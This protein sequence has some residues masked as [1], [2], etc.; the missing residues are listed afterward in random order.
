MK[1]SAAEEFAVDFFRVPHPRFV[2]VGLGFSCK[3]QLREPT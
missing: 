2:R 3:K 1:G